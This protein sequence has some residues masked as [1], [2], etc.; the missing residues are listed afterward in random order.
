[1]V[2]NKFPLHE[3]KKNKTSGNDIEHKK[4]AFKYTYSRRIHIYRHFTTKLLLFSY[5]PTANKSLLSNDLKS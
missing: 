4:A 1:M 3:V 2:T 5:C